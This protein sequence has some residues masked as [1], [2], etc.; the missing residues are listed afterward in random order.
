MSKSNRFA[1]S[2]RRVGSVSATDA[3]KGFGGLVDRVR[4]QGVSYVVE[5]GGRPVAEIV[6]FTAQRATLGEL[7]RLLRDR[8]SVGEPFARAAS[9]AVRRANRPTVP[10]DPW[11]S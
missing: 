5:R 11:A 7:V 6:P 1:A 8:R 4:E 2:V 9:D 10:P 3:A